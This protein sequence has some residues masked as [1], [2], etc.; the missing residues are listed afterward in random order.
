M[1]RPVATLTQA[2]CAL[3]GAA[4]LPRDRWGELSLAGGAGAEKFHARHSNA[5]TSRRQGDFCL[6]LWKCC[7]RWFQK[8]KLVRRAKSEKAK[9][10]KNQK[11]K[12]ELKKKRLDARA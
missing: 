7:L 6:R 1:L 5:I 4:F 12:K 2:A 11:K 10:K 8:A 3:G 9:R